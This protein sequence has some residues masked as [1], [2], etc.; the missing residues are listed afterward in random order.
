MDV[1]ARML[2]RKSV[3]VPRVAELPIFQ[4]ILQGCALL[5]GK[6][7]A[8]LAVVRVLL[9][10]T[11]KTLLG[12]PFASK[13]SCPVNCAEELKQYTPVVSVL[14]PRSWP[15]RLKLH[16]CPARLLYAVVR[17]LSARLLTASPVCI[18]PVTVPGGNPVT[19]V[20]GLTPRSPITVVE[21]VLVMALPA[22]A[23]KLAA[24]PNGGRTAARAGTAISSK[25]SNRSRAVA[26]EYLPRFLMNIKTA[27]DATRRL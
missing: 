19:A 21:P 25:D 22:S 4:K 24:V 5:M 7:M 10:W 2:P 15:V 17:S 11:M 1:S 6:M 8:L 27:W 12:L 3:L 23:P 26:A 20:P 16:A 9:I 13:M 18:V 14:P